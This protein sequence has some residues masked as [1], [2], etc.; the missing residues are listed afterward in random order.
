MA[1][2]QN[3]QR[4]DILDVI[5]RIDAGTLIVPP[6]QCSTKYCT[7]YQGKH[8]PPKYLV[9][10]ANVKPNGFPLWTHYGGDETNTFLATR[11]FKC[12]AH[13]GAP[14]CTKGAAI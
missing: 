3:I 8:Y 7:V 2:P 9:R 13:G 11:G 1:I 5:R 4:S 10:E 12:T 14:Y 6:K